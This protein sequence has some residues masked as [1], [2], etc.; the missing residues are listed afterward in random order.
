MFEI[1]G[2]ARAFQ[3][4]D[5]VLSGGFVVELADLQHEA[6]ARGRR[7]RVRGRGERFCCGFGSFGLRCRARGGPEFGFRLL[8]RGDVCLGLCRQRG[9]ERLLRLL[10]LLKLRLSHARRD[11]TGCRRPVVCNARLRFGIGRFTRFLRAGRD[12]AVRDVDGDVVGNGLGLRIQHHRQDDDRS[13]HQR[14]RADQTAARALLL[15]QG[16]IEHHRVG[17]GALRAA[18]AAFRAGGMTHAARG[19][20]ICV[21]TRVIFLAE[22]EKSHVW[23]GA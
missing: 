3:L 2:H 22:R 9:S 1:C 7:R 16:G 6:A 8:G 21:A 4:V 20:G 14:D 15:R 23:L 10:R 19:I 5:P 13:Q 11:A 17:V 12:R 18:R